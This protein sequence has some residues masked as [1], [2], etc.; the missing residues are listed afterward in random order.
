MNDRRRAEIT[1]AAAFDHGQQMLI[2]VAGY[3]QGAG[4]RLEVIQSPTRE[5]P[6]SFLIG[7]IAGNPGI[8]PDAPPRREAVWA[9]E[10]LPRVGDKIGILHQ[11][12]KTII[13]VRKAVVST[14]EENV[15]W[16]AIEDRMPPGPPRLRVVGKLLAPTT[17]FKATLEPTVP[18][19][20]NPRILMLDLLVTPPSGVEPQVI[21]PL[22]VRFEKEVKQGEH[23]S[24]H[25]R[26]DG[27]LLSKDEQIE[28]QIV[29]LER[30]TAGAGAGGGRRK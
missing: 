16:W 24:G 1:A 30:E 14:T 27:T 20:I 13:P 19:G 9:A 10:L 21:T 23:T 8:N 29:S 12:G 15:G 6:P 2:Y 22:S 26:A 28:V 11:E 7:A 18:Q 25:I 3:T 4:G 17:G 5:F